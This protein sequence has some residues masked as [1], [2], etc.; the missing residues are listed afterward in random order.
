MRL[1]VL[2]ETNPTVVGAGVTTLATYTTRESILEEVARI[3]ADAQG[4]GQGARRLLIQE[5]EVDT[6]EDFKGDAP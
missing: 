2:F 1:Y 3:E 6:L 5:I 4:R